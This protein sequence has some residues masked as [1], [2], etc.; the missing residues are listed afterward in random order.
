MLFENVDAVDHPV[1]E[2]FHLLRDD[3]TSLVPYLPDVQEIVVLE[4]EDQA[5]GSVRIVNLWRGSGSQVP[6]LV[7]KFM[8]AEWLSWKDHAV[9]HTE[10]TRRAEWR[11]EPNVGGKLF[12][13]T[14]Q[15]SVLE[16]GPGRT[17]I[18]IQGDLRVYPER[19][20][21]VPRL[22]AGKVRGSIESFVVG[23]LT[24]NMKTMARGVQRFFDDQKRGA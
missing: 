9:W 3:M 7:Q 22:L 6:A 17:R 4:R 23:L 11:L 5:G 20:P 13:C 18:K 21:G 1:E 19:F 24:P 2:V 15:T 14:G 12:E 8:K 16:D 10:G